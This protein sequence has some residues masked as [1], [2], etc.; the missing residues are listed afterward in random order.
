M[1]DG[2][3][4]SKNTSQPAVSAVI[5]HASGH[6]AFS[7]GREATKRDFPGG[8]WPTCNVVGVSDPSAS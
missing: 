6:A 3:L 8:C 4:F 7:E 1:H 2:Q 5:L